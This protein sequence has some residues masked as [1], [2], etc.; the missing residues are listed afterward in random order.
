M[1]P[2]SPLSSPLTQIVSFLT[3]MRLPEMTEIKASIERQK[4]IAT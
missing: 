3:R 4:L 2:K 1:N